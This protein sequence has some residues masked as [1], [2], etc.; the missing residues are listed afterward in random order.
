MRY[1]S[2]ARDIFESSSRHERLSKIVRAFKGNYAS[3]SMRLRAPHYAAANRTRDTFITADNCGRASYS[4]PR[5]SRP[6]KQA[7]RSRISEKAFSLIGHLASRHYLSYVDPNVCFSTNLKE[8]LAKV[9]STLIHQSVR[10][11]I[12]RTILY[13][14]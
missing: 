11:C 4:R 13:K 12:M 8:Q 9:A 10:T 5:P 7:T 1:S 6:E 3:R 2:M 14:V